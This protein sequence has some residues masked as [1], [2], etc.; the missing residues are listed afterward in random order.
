MPALL[1]TLLFV[2]IGWYLIIRP[3]QQRVRQQQATIAALQVGDRVITA[4]GIYGTLVEV[5]DETV[6]IEVAPDTVLTLARPAIARRQ[7]DAADA[8]DGSADADAD[9]D[10]DDP[11]NH[12]TVDET[13]SSNDGSTL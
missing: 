4:G 2:G 8:P 10:A 13:D 3:Q 9:A 1:L 6:R 7:P 12:D 11:I 5:D